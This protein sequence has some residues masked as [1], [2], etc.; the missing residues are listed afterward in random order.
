MNGRSKLDTDSIRKGLALI[1]DYELGLIII[2][3]Q[4]LGSAY[5]SNTAW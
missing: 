3:S 2:I 4:Q 5:F 1:Y